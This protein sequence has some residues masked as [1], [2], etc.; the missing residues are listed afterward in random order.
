MKIALENISKS[1]YRDPVLSNFS[2]TLTQPH[3]YAV[4]GPNGSGKSTLLQIM[5][6]YVTPSSGK[7]SHFLHDR[8]LPKTEV[9]RHLSAATPLLELPQELTLTEFLDFHFNMKKIRP[10][11]NVDEV[12]KQAN[13]SQARHKVLRHF[14][15][16]MRQ[17]VK[18]LSAL[19]ADTPAVFLDEPATNLDRQGTDWYRDLV[20]QT[21]A[22]RL[23]VI[24]SN[25]NESE[26]D[27]CDH[28]LRMEDFT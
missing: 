1:Y 21:R 15:S 20:T 8:P 9:F 25:T 27:F 10:G 22:N 11:F 4:L 19:L 2:F 18:L 7:L 6:G 3:A 12:L 26:Y 5:T 13:L 24:A 16:G 23:V 14:S 28:V 17:K